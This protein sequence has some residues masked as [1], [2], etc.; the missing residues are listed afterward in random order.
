M[1][2]SL[3]S[4]YLLPLEQQTAILNG[5][6]LDAPHG[7]DPDFENPPNQNTLAVTA[8]T[9]SLALITTLVLL[10]TYAKLVIAGKLQLQD[11]ICFLSY[12]SLI[13]FIYNIYSFVNGIGLFVHQ[14]DVLVRDL[15]ETFQIAANFYVAALLFIK[16]SILLDWLNIFVPRGTRG[17]FFWVC[18]IFIWFKGLF[19][20]SMEIAGNLSCRPFNRI[21]DKTVPGDCFKRAPLDI[22][23]GAVNILCDIFI[24]LA[25][26]KVIWSLRMNKARKT[27]VSVVFA[28]G[29]LAIASAIG[30]LVATVE[31]STTPDF[32]YAMSKLVLWSL[33]EVTLG[34][35]VFCV[36]SLPRI[37]QESSFLSRIARSLSS[38]MRRPNRGGDDVWR[39]SAAEGREYYRMPDVDNYHNPAS[40]QRTDPMKHL[41]AQDKFSGDAMRRP[42]GNI[43]RTTEFIA[44]EERHDQPQTNQN[45]PLHHTWETSQQFCRGGA[46]HEEWVMS[47]VE[48]V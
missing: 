1:S 15:N 46:E 41:K 12:L 8:T 28:V 10:R 5:P 17:S 47:H 31:Y 13:G 35:V 29:L 3:D 44:R 30:R 27:G 26:Q 19:Y 6:A 7:I 39:G 32:T 42:L 11:Y 38:K 24:F 14:W 22:T 33:A 25:P 23:V 20:T 2:S 16:T 21:W 18:H 34:F 48:S 43:T 4:L 36:P 9:V 37:F 45:A 40:H